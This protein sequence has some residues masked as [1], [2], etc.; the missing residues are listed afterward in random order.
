MH[1]KLVEAHL[2]E[3]VAICDSRLVDHD[4][5]PIALL[6]RIRRDYP[7]RVVLRRKVE[8]A[9]ERVLTL[10]GVLGIAEIELD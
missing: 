5:D 6:H 7:N 1:R 4:A 9:P 2:G 8:T 10:N 3:T